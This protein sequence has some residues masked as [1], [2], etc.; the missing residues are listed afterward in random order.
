MYPIDSTHVPDRGLQQCPTSRPLIARAVG[1]T[2]LFGGSRT[3]LVQELL[4]EQ[5]PHYGLILLKRT[6]SLYTCF[7]RQLARQLKERKAVHL[8]QSR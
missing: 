7:L 2:C 3:A 1:A 5:M 4:M 6:Q 8:V